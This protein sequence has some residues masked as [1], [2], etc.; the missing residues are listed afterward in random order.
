MSCTIPQNT[1]VFYL[2]FQRFIEKAYNILKERTI[3]TSVKGKG[4]YVVKTP[5]ISS[6]MSYNETPL[7][8]LLGITT[9]SRGIVYSCSNTKASNSNPSSRIEKFTVCT[10]AD[11]MSR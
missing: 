10:P 2:L 5:L 8:E 9:I 6:L 7:K 1:D 11:G 4:F 3:I